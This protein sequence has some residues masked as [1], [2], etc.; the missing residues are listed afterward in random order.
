MGEAL[1]RLR[2]SLY[3]L[4]AL[5]IAAASLP[6]YIHIPKLYA[7]HYG[8]SLATIGALLL[9]V[10]L[11]D[12][13]QDPIIGY[14]S[15]KAVSRGIS[16]MRMMQWSLP[17]FALAMLALVYPLAPAY[18]ALWLCVTL[19]ALYTCFG[20]VSINYYAFGAEWQRD[21]H[22]QI[23]ISAW[24]ESFVLIG[25]LLASVL[26]QVFS[27]AMGQV[28]GM[29]VFGVLIAG[30]CVLMI[31]LAKWGLPAPQSAPVEASTLSLRG[32]WRAMMKSRDYR[33]LLIIFFLNGFANSIPATVVLFYI[34]DVLELEAQSGYFLGL[35]FLAGLLGIPLWLWL[36]RRIGKKRCLLI[37]M[38]ASAI[39][40]VW[41]FTLGAG[42]AT[43]FYLVCTL[44]GLCLGA[45]MAMPPALLGDLLKREGHDA[46]GAFFG[47][48]N[49]VWKLTFALAAGIVLPALAWAGYDPS[50]TPD[51]SSLAGLSFA[52]A[53]APS[54]IKCV[55]ALLLWQS[56]IESHHDNQHPS[57]PESPMRL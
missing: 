27:N 41:A 56:P 49:M 54:L 32:A 37:S 10:R 42:D 21:Y 31:P 45:D 53:L 22:A 25:I 50:G 15:D 12:T 1:S 29:Q 18:A 11:I 33:W 13:L 16:R 55:A 35:Y 5:P 39:A 34:A 46:T 19:V 6:I 44:S 24:R 52:Y 14:L 2:L 23:R 57:S 36:A 30:W 20:V 9:L 3:G 26:P 28:V 17:L 51:A 43:A 48:W 4:L 7:Q 47:V 8:I 38:I 40:F